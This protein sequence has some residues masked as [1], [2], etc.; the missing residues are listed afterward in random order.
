[1]A[2]G[3]AH[4]LLNLVKLVRSALSLCTCESAWAK[5]F[6]DAGNELCW[7]F[8]TEQPV[9][10]RMREAATLPQVADAVAPCSCPQAVPLLS[11]LILLLG[12]LGYLMV[13]FRLMPTRRWAQSINSAALTSSEG[14]HVPTDVEVAPAARSEQRDKAARAMYASAPMKQHGT[15][16]THTRAS[17]SAFLCCLPLS[18]VDSPSSW[19]AERS[20]SAHVLYP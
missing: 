12:E 15:A 7:D 18:N 4:R 16:A 14:G 8:D 9:P 2:S 20:T 6:G 13:D 11:Q 1:M 19:Q 10:D 3:L 17:P 5:Q